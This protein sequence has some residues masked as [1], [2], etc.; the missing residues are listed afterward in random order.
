MRWIISMLLVLM[1]AGGAWSQEEA[2]CPK[3]DCPKPDVCCDDL[4]FVESV[5]LLSWREA[6]CIEI[7][8]NTPF[9]GG[10]Y[11]VRWGVFNVKG[12]KVRGGGSAG[13]YVRPPGA[14][15]FVFEQS[16]KLL[17]QD[18]YYVRATVKKFAEPIRNER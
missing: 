9:E 12:K 8:I 3:L 15:N 11:D 17:Q 14:T 6:T 5:R 10:M 18:E 1:L 13:W 7:Y 2:C 16:M 4:V